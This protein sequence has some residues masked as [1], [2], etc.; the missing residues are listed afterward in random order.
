MEKQLLHSKSYFIEGNLLWCL[1][2]DI[3][4]ILTIDTD[5]WEQNCI[6]YLDIDEDVC[7][8]YMTK[9]KSSVY[10]ISS[11]Q[12]VIAE[13]DL[14]H[15][16]TTYYRHNCKNNVNIQIA[17]LN[18]KIYIFPRNLKD[19]LICF[20]LQEKNFTTSK[21]WSKSKEG[22]I[23]LSQVVN[24]H[25]TFIEKKKNRILQYNFGQD[26]WNEIPYSESDVLSGVY[27]Q[28]RY[29]YVTVENK[30]KVLRINKKDGESSCFVPK[31]DF[32]GGYNN[33][34]HGGNR[35][36]LM[37]GNSMDYLDELTGEINSLDDLPEDLKN[38]NADGKGTLFFGCCFVP[39]GC[40]FVPWNANVFLVLNKNTNKWESKRIEV[41]SDIMI[42]H[43]IEYRTKRSLPIDEKSVSVSEYLKYILGKE[44]QI[45]KHCDDAIGVQIYN[46]LK[47]R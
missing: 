18:E 33:L 28:D 11:N 22:F 26:Q 25:I 41:P 14:E 20:D 44:C 6:C 35:L 1:S 21:N 30:R 31:K 3:N 37:T 13:Y 39:R 34:I 32:T 42:K 46:K 45:N 23:Y 9:Y 27:E 43:Y 24:D 5:T 29:V 4:C 16:N 12:C 15:Q 38:I 17:V 2:R 8:H 19:D 7:F 36:Y 40:L 10:C 47:E